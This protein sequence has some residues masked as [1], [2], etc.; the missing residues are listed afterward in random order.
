M[1]G[2]V[3]PSVHRSKETLI[4]NL[5]RCNTKVLNIRVKKVSR[6]FLKTAHAVKQQVSDFKIRKQT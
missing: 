5:Y 4:L 3:Y 2:H 6:N 1:G